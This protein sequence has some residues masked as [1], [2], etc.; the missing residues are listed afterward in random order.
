MRRFRPAWFAVLLVLFPLLS[1]CGASGSTHPAKPLVLTSF[2]PLYYL[3]AQIAGDRAEVRNLVPAG[4]EPHDWEPSTR[5]VADLQKAALFVYNGA[6]F[7]SWVQK[8]LAATPEKSR[9]VVEAAQ[10]LPLIAPPSGDEAGHFTV[11]PHI[12][13]DPVLAKQIAAKIAAGLIQADPTGQA[14]FEQNL[15]DLNR[16]LDDLN[17]AYTNGLH[18]CTRR[19]IIT[20][21][22][23]FGYLAQRYHLNQIAVEGLA[24]D[25][26]P[27]PARIAAIVKLA[28]DTGAKYIFFETLVSPRVAQTIASEAG[29]QTLTLDPLEGIKDEQKQNYFTVMNDNLTNLRLALDCH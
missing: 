11:D 16:R 7:E 5:N 13:L 25:A 26:E 15:A 18:D 21:H 24:P 12:W 4:V 28:R 20:S 29:A 23:A 19:D 9:V 17:T 1:A 2:Y 8:T 14:T 27:T 22:A 3:T 10:G 6:G